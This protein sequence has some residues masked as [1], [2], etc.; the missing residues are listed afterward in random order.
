ER[1]SGRGRGDHIVRLRLAVPNP[2][3]LSEE[4]LDL[5]RRLAESEGKEVRG[6]RR[7]FDRVRD[8]FG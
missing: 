6:E 3:E 4:H 5:L 1:L 7:V 2:R 8:L